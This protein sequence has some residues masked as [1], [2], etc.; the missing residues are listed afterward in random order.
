MDFVLLFETGQ[1]KRLISLVTSVRWHLHI[2]SKTKPKLHIGA[3]IYSKNVV[4]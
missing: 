2:Q 1:V 3:E 4:N